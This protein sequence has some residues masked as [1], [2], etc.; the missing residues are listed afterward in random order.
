[1]YISLR[2]KH[3]TSAK[4][5]NEPEYYPTPANYLPDVETTITILLKQLLP[6]LL[7]S[8]SSKAPTTI[9]MLQ[10]TGN[11]IIKLQLSKLRDSYIFENLLSSPEPRW[12]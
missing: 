6:D 11:R 12:H 10:M 2:Y 7:W 3:K 1:M 4:T 5:R 8:V 9:I